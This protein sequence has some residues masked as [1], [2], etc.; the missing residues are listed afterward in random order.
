MIVFNGLKFRIRL[1]E[2]CNIFP[3]PIFTFA[4]WLK[5]TF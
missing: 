1:N 3:F 4:L 2:G 5:T